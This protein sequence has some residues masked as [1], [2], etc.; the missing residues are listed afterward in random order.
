MFFDQPPVVLVRIAVWAAAGVILHDFVF[1]G[2]FGTAAEL[3][4]APESS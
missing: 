1:A 4:S 3:P 2:A